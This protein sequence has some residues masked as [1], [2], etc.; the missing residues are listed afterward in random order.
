MLVFSWVEGVVSGGAKC[1]AP[2]RKN[3]NE[4]KRNKKRENVCRVSCYLHLPMIICRVS[5]VYT[6]QR[7]CVLIGQHKV[8]TDHASWSSLSLYPASHLAHC[9]HPSLASHISLSCSSPLSHRHVE[10]LASLRMHVA[11]SLLQIDLGNSLLWI[12]LETSLLRIHLA[13]S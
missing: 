3:S 2:V 1:G 11:A 9:R 13:A 4:K 12:D 7:C 10:R 6:C 8:L 5:S